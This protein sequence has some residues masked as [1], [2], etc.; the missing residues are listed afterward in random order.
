MALIDLSNYAT[1]LFQ[2]STAAGTDGN[3]FFD[4]V[5]GTVQFFT[6]TTHPTLNLTAHGGAAGAANPLIFDATLRAFDRWT[7]GTF[8]FGGAYNF[9]NG[10]TPLA[11]AD[12]ALIRGSGWNEYDAA[13]VVQRIYFGNKGLSNIGATSQPYYQL[14]HFTTAVNYAKA[15]QI[16][17]AVLVGGAAATNN[18]LNPEIVSV[19]TYGNNYD[20]KSTSVD[21]GITELG[22]YSTGF[23]I[24]ESPHLTT[25]V[26]GAHPFASVWTT[27]AGAW[28]NV[29]LAKLATPLAV[30]GF[31]EGTGNFSWVI[32]NPNGSTLDQIVAYLDAIATVTTDI[33]SGAQTVTIGK[34]VDVWYTYNAA[35][36][37][38][39]KS[40]ADNLG[41]YIYNIPVA[42]QQRVIFT[43][44]AGTTNSYLFTVGVTVNVGA[45]AK[46]DPNAWYHSYFAAGYNTAAA[47]AVQDS[48]AAVV[49]GNASAANVNNEIVF[50]FDYDGDT[51]G[52]AAG[53]NKNAVFVCEG[54]GGATQAK[55]LYT[56]T[57]VTSLSFACAP[58]AENNV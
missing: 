28:L 17:E 10:R 16:D 8:K 50:G 11:N 21:L 30:A 34:D 32:N 23:A 31:A 49:T 25:N 58:Q 51:I 4:R 33:D 56:L 2:A 53:T 54:D 39:T 45:T 7:S 1:S 47:V 48:T 12:R 41:L 44:D 20:R 19:R 13:G 57:R 29:S 26:G 6:A 43:N 36:Q 37:V 9:V 46:A 52:G 14:G 27:P 24:N 40:G 35:G 42:D 15:G 5:N 22:G 55:T 18:T 3:V 38:V